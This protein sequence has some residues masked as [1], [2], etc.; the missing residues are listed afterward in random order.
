MEKPLQNSN[1]LR[2]NVNFLTITPAYPIIFQIK[3][4]CK[5]L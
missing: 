1:V 5:P 2:F 3:N 4:S